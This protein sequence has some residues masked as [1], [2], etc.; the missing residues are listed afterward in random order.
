MAQEAVTPDRLSDHISIG[1]L[2]QTFTPE[3][4]D[5]MVAKAGRTEKR[6]RLLPARV[7]VYF[8]LAMCLFSRESY[9][10]VM[11]LLV[12]GLRWTE[13][14]SP[15]WKLP[16]DTAIGAAR[17]RLGPEPL[18]LLF[19]TAV[20]PL[21]A[22]G[23]V[24]SFYRQW[25]MVAID[26]TTLDLADTADNDAVYGRPGS[27][28]EDRAAFPQARVLGLV[29]CGTHAVIG[30]CIG[31]YGDS[32]VALAPELFGRLMPGMLNLNDRGFWSYDLWKQARHSGADLLWRVKSTLSLPVL[33]MFDDGSYASEIRSSKD[34]K[35]SEPIA[36]RVIEYQLEGIS[37]ETY[38][39]VTTILDPNEA[40]ADELAGLYGQRWEIES[41][42]NELKTHQRGR[43]AV[44]RSKYPETVEQEIWAHLLVHYALRLLMAD[45][46]T[47][48][49]VDPDR[50]SFLNAL[51][52]VRRQVADSAAISPL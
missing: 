1:V 36:V 18:Q 40:P 4:I 16:T 45:A 39:L 44:L 31:A 33:E 30:A 47:L 42:F 24:E 52:I 23:A 38:R 6:V 27:K 7:V 22:P 17:R 41:T 9:N 5:R 20:K 3:L 28:G 14:W 12:R 19:K 10:E 32:E 21:A 8:T 13:Q 35:N 49:G 51:R 37:D 46:A 26:G 29:E 48:A 50:T 11:A 43:G 34:R 25:R 15:S 2:T